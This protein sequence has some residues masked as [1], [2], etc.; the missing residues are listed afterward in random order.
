MDARDEL[1]K[2]RELKRELGGIQE[3]GEKEQVSITRADEKRGWIY[4]RIYY[5]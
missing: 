3:N 4:A 1:Q 5:R 2:R